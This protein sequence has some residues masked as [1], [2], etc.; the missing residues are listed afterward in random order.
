[1][2]LFA[3]DKTLAHRSSAYAIVREAVAEV[4]R[5]THMTSADG[6]TRHD[7]TYLEHFRHEDR[8]EFNS[9]QEAQAAYF[10]FQETNEFNEKPEGITLW[11]GKYGLR[12]NICLSASGSSE[13]SWT[14]ANRGKDQRGTRAKLWNTENVQFRSPNARS[15]TEHAALGINS[16]L[17]KVRPCIY[18]LLHSSH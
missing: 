9:L 18:P 15:L 10:R 5:C 3:C 1:M 2:H 13:T 17:N 7:G 14:Y 6:W 4:E 8:F 12:W 11:R 16:L